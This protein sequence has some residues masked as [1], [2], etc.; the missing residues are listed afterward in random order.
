ME[1][2]TELSERDK[3]L[4]TCQHRLQELGHGIKMREDTCSKLNDQLKDVMKT[5][6]S[7]T[8]LIERTKAES[9]DATSKIDLLE[10]EKRNYTR[11]L[12]KLTSELFK[13]KRMRSEVCEQRRLFSPQNRSLNIPSPILY[14]QTI[15]ERDAQ[16]ETA[17]QIRKELSQAEEKLKVNEVVVRKRE[18][19]LE[20]KD[21][22][23]N[24]MK[25]RQ[26]TAEES[27]A[28]LLETR[29]KLIEAE[30]SLA[31]TNSEVLGLK[32]EL[33]K[34]HR[35]LESP[36]NVHRWRKLEVRNR[37]FALTDIMS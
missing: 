8:K 3:K 7:L 30:K 17:N 25:S 36:V 13:E 16:K 6:S 35:Q 33:A 11:Q 19:E 18:Q 37:T 2:Q 23:L 5:R 1:L 28:Q 32:V 20:G 24:M 4:S 26:K 14:L 27:N 34:L 21:S 10:N 9:T 15:H 22:A 29:K 31:Q 12:S